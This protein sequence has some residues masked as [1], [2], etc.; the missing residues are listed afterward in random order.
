MS[1]MQ[2]GQLERRAQRRCSVATGAANGDGRSDIL[3]GPGVG[4]P[5][6][7]NV[8]RSHGGSASNHRRTHLVMAIQ[9]GE[10][11]RSKF[12]MEGSEDN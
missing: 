2:R 4:V 5:P 3:G 6:S 10:F 11:R 8:K 7:R 12:K 9:S 1:S